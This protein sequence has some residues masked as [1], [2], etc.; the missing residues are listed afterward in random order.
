MVLGAKGDWAM[1]VEGGWVENNDPVLTVMLAN[2]CCPDAH[3]DD[4]NDP[5]RVV[6][7]DKVDVHVP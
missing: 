7:C 6:H 5:K 1:M 4:P 2:L 3:P